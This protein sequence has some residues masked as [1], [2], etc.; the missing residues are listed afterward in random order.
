M[1]NGKK[2]ISALI[3]I[4]VMLT[5][6]FVAPVMAAEG[7]DAVSLS[8]DTKTIVEMENYVSKLSVAMKSKTGD[9]TIAVSALRQGVAA[10]KGILYSGDGY[11]QIDNNDKLTGYNNV[12]SEA[13]FEFKV[14]AERTGTYEMAWVAVNHANFSTYK[15]YVDDT[16]QQTDVAC[17]YVAKGVDIANAKNTWF[18]EWR[19]NMV[20]EYKKPVYLEAGQHTIKVQLSELSSGRIRQEFDYFSFEPLIVNKKDEIR[21]ELE[22]YLDSFEVE[23]NGSTSVKPGNGA[24]AKWL[25]KLYSGTGYMNIDTNGKTHKNEKESFDVNVQIPED[26]IYDIEWVAYNPSAINSSALDV[27]IDDGVGLISTATA[28]KKAVS[29]SSYATEPK[30]VSDCW[31]DEYRTGSMVNQYNKVLYLTQ[32]SHKVTFELTQYSATRYRQAI[33]YIGFTPIKSTVS[34]DKKTRIEAENYA[35]LCRVTK[36][37]GTVSTATKRTISGDLA[38]GESWL[39]LEIAADGNNPA[40]AYITIP[41]DTEKSGIYNVEYVIQGDLGT[42]GIYLDSIESKNLK[43]TNSTKTSKVEN[44]NYFE[45][46]P[47]A[48]AFTIKDLYITAGS[49]E[50]ILTVKK[51]EKNRLRECLD[52]VEFTPNTAIIQIDNTLRA[53]VVYNTAKTGKT[54]LAVYDDSGKLVNVDVVDVNASNSAEFEIVNFKLETAAG[55]SKIIFVDNFEDLTPD[56]AAIEF[57]F[58]EG[59]WTTND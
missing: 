46:W 14:N 33:D 13:S 49:H 34:Y 18:D 16:E 32:G 10:M 12:S 54:V 35:E 24:Y 21:Y 19:S 40:Y 31:F 36:T 50:L 45:Y 27:K 42:D 4:A 44:K 47:Q 39:K 25:G 52:Y 41:F 58:S 51:D 30:N 26:G 3:A 5:C 15:I 17:T 2:I 9:E 7:T 43:P 53:T 1:K 29:A 6:T 38:S 23:L 59:K 57:V 22:N 56:G 55:K 37:D 48:T 28:T 8:A 20:Y 11:M